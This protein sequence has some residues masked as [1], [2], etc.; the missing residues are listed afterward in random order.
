MKTELTNPE[1]N[2]P[3]AIKT[4]KPKYL[5]EEMA[6]WTDRIAKRAYELFQFNGFNDGHNLDDWFAAEHEFLKPVAVEVKDNKNEFIV[7]AEVPGFEAKDLEI[8]VDGSCLVIKGKHETRKEEK[9][10]EGKTIYTERT[11]EQIYRMIELPAPVLTDK[12]QAEIKNGVLELK[13]PKATTP[14]SIMITAA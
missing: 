4:T 13:L 1:R 14:K 5:F 11:A 8:D 12:A 3:I 6:E 2:L 10:K 7:R 9:E